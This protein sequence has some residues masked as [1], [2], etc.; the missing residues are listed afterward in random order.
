MSVCIEL[1]LLCCHAAGLEMQSKEQR[2]T[3]SPCLSL[4][5]LC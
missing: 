4:C 2:A 1:T 3:I 5:C